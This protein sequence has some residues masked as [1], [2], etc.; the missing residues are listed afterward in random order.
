MLL[1]KLTHLII[2]QQVRL[3]NLSV[4]V[5][6]NIIIMGLGFVTKVTIAN[7]LGK[8]AFG[9]FAYGIALGTFGMVFVR[10]GLDK[11]L[12]RDLIHYPKNFS[13]LVSSS[14]ILRLTIFI[15]IL[16]A[17]L[18]TKTH[19]PE[20]Q[21][22]SVGIIFIAIATTVISLDLQA[23]YDSWHKMQRHAIY[24][25]IH[26][27]FYFSV[28]W[29][30]IIFTPDQ[31]AIDIIGYAMLTAAVLYLVLQYNWAIRRI[32]FSGVTI[33]VI[34]STCIMAKNNFLVYM[35]ALGGLLIGTLNQILLKNIS[36]DEHLG[37]YS[38][39]WILVSLAMVL[40][41]QIARI[42]NPLLAK[43]TMESTVKKERKM[44]FIKYASL[45]LLVATPI[46]IPMIIFPEF[47]L[48]TIY[49]PEYITAAPAMQIL[50]A[51]VIIFSIGLAASQ[52]I[53]SCRKEK[54]YLIS[55]IIGGFISVVLCY[56]LIPKYHAVG[57]ALALLIS[58]GLSIGIYYVGIFRD[59]QANK[60]CAL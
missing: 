45:M 57:A 41:M 50:G 4:L 24:N 58:H 43:T 54:L 56:T 3:K 1:E 31:L 22:L 6:I 21:G 42:G 30:V 8:E 60:T 52:Y 16:A 26:K 25:L 10:F 12:V 23:V 20:T 19:F 55:V 39:A 44:F 34:Q 2:S 28:L 17:I 14:I 38:S 7:I 13:I 53:V 29:L 48:S 15:L 37:D 59:L 47:I 11:T 51:Y 27:C 36:G 35:A 9:Q 33:S 18:I 49:N 40:L 5:G 32:D 46:G